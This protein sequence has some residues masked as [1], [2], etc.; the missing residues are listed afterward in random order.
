MLEVILA[1]LILSR[2]GTDK[3]AIDSF[4]PTSPSRFTHQATDIG[5]LLR[6]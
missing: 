3:A 1:D 6:D 5:G 2:F 4:A